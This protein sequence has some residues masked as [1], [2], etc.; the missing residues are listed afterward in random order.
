MP[1]AA[2]VTVPRESLPV[3]HLQNHIQNHALRADNTLHVIGVVSNPVRYHSRY[4]LARAW[5]EEMR[6][7]PGVELHMVEAAFG[8]RHHEVTDSEGACL[9]LRTRS[10]LWIKENLI[11][12]GVRHLLPR[13]WRYAAWVDCDVTFRDPN[14][15]RETIHQLQHWPVV[16]PWQQCA[17]IGFTGN[18][19]QT[20]Q[21]FGFLH[22]R[23]VKKQ[24]HSGQPYAYGHSGFA[25]A[26]TRE[27]WEQAEGLM[28]FCILGSADHHMAWAM[29]GEVEK[30]IHHKMRPSFFRRCREW[31]A[32]ALR[33]TH[34][35]VGFVEG[36]I[37]HGFHGP[38]ARRYYRE[39]WQVLVDHGYDPDTD[40]VRDAQ[41]LIQLA[42]RHELEQALRRYNR[43][44]AEDSIEET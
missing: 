9:Q 12:L 42:G 15:A 26:C 4:R 31:Q 39:R 3:Q 18:I 29:V 7:T 21:S 20:H 27:F 17:D 5:Q 43:S 44:R 10:E 13:D 2:D 16:Q 11:N 25:W 28:D 33:V 37:E 36:R 19:L 14:W 8:D 1:R 40:L 38:K 30:T 35:Q 6:A 34:G 24:E 32:R 41:G 23:G 22:Q